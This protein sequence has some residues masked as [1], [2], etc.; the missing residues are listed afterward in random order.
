MPQLSAAGCGAEAHPS[1]HDPRPSLGGCLRASD[2]GGA[3]YDEASRTPAALPPLSALGWV[4][5]TQ[6]LL[7]KKK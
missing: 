7:K 5:K 6:K 1:P 4:K 3:R 2:G